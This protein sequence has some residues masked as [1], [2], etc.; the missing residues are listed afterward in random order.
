MCFLS[1]ILSLGFVI[2]PV[3]VLVQTLRARRRVVEELR[4]ARRADWRQLLVELKSGEEASFETA[5]REVERAMESL[6]VTDRDRII[7]FKD[8]PRNAQ[9]RYVLQLLRPL[10]ESE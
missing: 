1:A 7:R 5:I 3:V 8:Q 10:T 9:L 6:E 4:R 2:V